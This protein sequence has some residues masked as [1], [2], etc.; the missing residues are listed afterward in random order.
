MFISIQGECLLC[1]LKTHLLLQL[2]S[3]KCSLRDKENRSFLRFKLSLQP[4]IL[5]QN[6]LCLT[7]SRVFPQKLLAA[8]PPPSASFP[9]SE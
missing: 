7:L 1:L 8:L 2:S 5:L 9:D 4:R 3:I 6:K